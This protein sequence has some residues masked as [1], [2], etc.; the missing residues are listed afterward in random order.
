MI[1]IIVLWAKLPRQEIKTE[2]IVIIIHYSLHLNT[3]LYY[4]CLLVDDWMMAPL[5]P[6]KPGSIFR[7]TDR[8]TS[9]H[10]PFDHANFAY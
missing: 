7:P 6:L 1:I 5:L 4:L 2:Y 3:I 8:P 10:P 9:V